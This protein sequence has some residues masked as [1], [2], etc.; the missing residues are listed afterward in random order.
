[1]HAGFRRVHGN[2]FCRIQSDNDGLEVGASMRDVSK[3]RTAGC[4]N[5]DCFAQQP[6]VYER[7]GHSRRAAGRDVARL[8]KYSANNDVEQKEAISYIQ[9]HS[10]LPVPQ[11]FA[12]FHTHWLMICGEERRCRGTQA[13]EF[14]G[15]SDVTSVGMAKLNLNAEFI[16]CSGKELRH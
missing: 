6:H 5:R 3:C 1:M 13:T 15:C 9:E 10:E 14:A 8:P 7:S 11:R 2:G 16:T 12:H 4:N